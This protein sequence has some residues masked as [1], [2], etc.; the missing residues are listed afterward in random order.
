MISGELKMMFTVV[1][2]SFRRFIY[3]KMEYEIYAFPSNL[4]PPNSFTL[5]VCL[6]DGS[7]NMYRF[8]LFLVFLKQI[9]YLKAIDS[10]KNRAEKLK[11]S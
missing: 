5:P 10:K 3:P 9:Q 1:G 6:V 8:Q 2:C 11:K 4:P 7:S